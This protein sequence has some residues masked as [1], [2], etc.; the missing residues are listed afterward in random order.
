MRKIML[1]PVHQDQDF[2]NQQIQLVHRFRK[3]ILSNGGFK[4]LD[5]S[6]AHLSEKYMQKAMTLLKLSNYE[7][8]VELRLDNCQLSVA[9]MVQLRDFL[10]Q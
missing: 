9:I 1:A 7:H 2:I 6:G 8:L 5:L 4:S 10:K 3:R